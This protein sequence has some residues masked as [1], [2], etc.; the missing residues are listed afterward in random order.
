[1]S[2]LERMKTTRDE[3]V[4]DLHLDLPI[5]TW[6]GGLIA[7]FKVQDREKMEKFGSRKRTID[8]DLDFIITATDSIW[9][10]DTE[11]ELEGLRENEEEGGLGEDYVRLEHENG[12]N[13]GF[14]AKLAELFN[15]PAKVQERARLVCLWCFDN[16]SI[17]LGTMVVKLIKWMSNTDEEVA[18]S[19]LGE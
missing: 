15:A 8:A 9:V 14:E 10:K 19:L 11:H 1:M 7:R 18:E 12:A 13:I 16:N 4:K 6:E 2:V 5:P 17:A 3:K